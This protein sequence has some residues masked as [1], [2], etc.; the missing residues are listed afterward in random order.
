MLHLADHLKSRI[1]G[2]LR[3]LSFFRRGMVQRLLA[4]SR[5]ESANSEFDDGRLSFLNNITEHDALI[6]TE[7]SQC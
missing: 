4:G 2:S 7:F 6:G 5:I 3:L 1:A